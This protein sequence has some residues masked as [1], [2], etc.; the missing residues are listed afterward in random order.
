MFGI[1]G[2]GGDV[3]EGGMDVRQIH[4]TLRSSLTPLSMSRNMK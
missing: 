2:H 3:E 1:S 4:R